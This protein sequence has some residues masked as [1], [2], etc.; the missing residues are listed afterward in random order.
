MKS[1]QLRSRAMAD[2]A[3]GY[4]RPPKRTQFVK[5]QSGNPSGRPEGSQNLAA[6][7]NATIRQRIKVTENGRIRYTTKFEAIIA[8]LVNKALRGDVNAIHELRYWIQFLEDSLQTSSQPLVTRE[9]DEAVVES[10]GTTAP[11]RKLSSTRFCKYRFERGAQMSATQQLTYAEYQAL[12]RL[13]LIT[14][15]ERSFYELNPQATF[16]R[17]L[18]IEVLATKLAASRRG[19]L[20]RL[21]VCIPPRMLKSIAVSVAFPAWL[22]GH[23][24]TKQIICASYG[25][26]LA[27][28]HARDCR[29]LIMSDFYRVLF[30]RTRL[31]PEKQSVNDFLT[32]AQGFRMS[33]SVGG[34]LTVVLVPPETGVVKIVAVS[35]DVS[36]NS[37]GDLLRDKF[38]AL[39]S[40]CLSKV[41]LCD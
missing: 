23:D 39:R 17:S 34:V 37:S 20:R 22:L 11:N 29:T 6:V 18:H 31:S 38:N 9:N 25:Q 3:V 28:K 41:G 13:D 15:I 24:P 36:T 21:I 27:E 2:D 35:S 26:D 5:G 40:S 7:L 4:G 10:F 12:L 32:T 19:Q 16:A 14:F 1:Q 33:T 8:Q 30:P